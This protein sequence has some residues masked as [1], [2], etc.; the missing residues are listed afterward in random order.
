MAS[1]S[2][3]P[4]PP[5]VSQHFVLCPSIASYIAK[6]RAPTPYVPKSLPQPRLRDLLIRALA[7]AV[8]PALELADTH[9]VLGLRLLDADGRP[10]CWAEGRVRE[11]ASAELGAR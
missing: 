11:S 10:R 4:F 5:E 1:P 2:L 9:R 7:A 8:E 6:R 3:I